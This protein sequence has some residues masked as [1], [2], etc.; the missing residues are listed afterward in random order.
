MLVALPGKKTSKQPLND[1]LVGTAAVVGWVSAG[2]E[3]HYNMVE[4]FLALL[5]VIHYP[6]LHV[7]L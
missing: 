2:P 7:S 6:P 5:I 3:L 4:Q 1:K